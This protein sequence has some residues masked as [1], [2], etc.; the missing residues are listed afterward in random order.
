MYL[1]AIKGGRTYGAVKRRKTSFTAK[2]AKAMALASW[3]KRR[4]RQIAAL[5]AARVPMPR[6][7]PHECVSGRVP[8]DRVHVCV[9]CGKE[10]P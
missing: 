7:D 10:M 5:A 1:G 4:A 3:A 6:V 2:T 8:G 9:L